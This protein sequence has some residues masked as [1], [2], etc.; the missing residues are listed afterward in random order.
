MKLE[1]AE[2]DEAQPVG[3][4][5]CEAL[6]LTAQTPRKPDQQQEYRQGRETN[7]QP[8]REAAAEGQ[9]HCHSADS[10]VNSTKS[11]GQHHTA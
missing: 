2:R 9:D 7:R 4:V 11:I 8:H 1:K 3:Q 5:Y 10:Q 6:D